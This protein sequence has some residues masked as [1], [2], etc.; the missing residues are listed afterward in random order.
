M[1]QG[2]EDYCLQHKCS[3]REIK[4]NLPFTPT[5]QASMQPLKFGE[6]N[7]KEDYKRRIEERQH[8]IYQ[9]FQKK[10]TYKITQTPHAHKLE[11]TKKHFLQKW[12]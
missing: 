12:K 6:K 2:T 7:S 5:A 8:K 10:L 3:W 9:L 1:L 11:Q 4:S